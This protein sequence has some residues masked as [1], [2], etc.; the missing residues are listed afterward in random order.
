[1]DHEFT[2]KNIAELPIISIRYKAPLGS[3]SDSIGRLYKNAGFNAC[4][5]L[6]NLYHDVECVEIADIETCVPVKKQ[7][8][9]NEGIEYKVLPAVTVLS[10][11]HT[12]SYDKIHETYSA[13]ENYVA[14]NNIKMIHPYRE[15]YHKGPGMIFKGNPAKYITEIMIQIEN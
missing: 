8:K 1:M 11:I 3:F 10:V 7:I 6:M 12:G 9:T 5:K 13:L 2:I 15:I 14:A 4:G